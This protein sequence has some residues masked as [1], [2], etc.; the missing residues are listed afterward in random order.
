MKVHGMGEFPYTG[1]CAKG[2]QR[3][4]VYRKRVK[5]LGSRRLTV[6]DL[7]RPVKTDAEVGLF[8]LGALRTAHQEFAHR[9]GGRD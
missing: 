8:Y 7:M 4:T 2:P 9:L 5:G 6:A 3:L 1:I